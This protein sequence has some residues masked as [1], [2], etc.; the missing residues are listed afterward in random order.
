MIRSILFTGDKFLNVDFKNIT[1]DQLEIN[2]FVKGVGEVVLN[3]LEFDSN[4]HINNCKKVCEVCNSDLAVV[5]K[6]EFDD[7]I[8]IEFYHKKLA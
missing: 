2:G 1:A 6:N 5:Y 4:K 7:K 3:K 8:T